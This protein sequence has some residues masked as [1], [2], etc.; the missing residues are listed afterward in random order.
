MLR[1]FSKFQ[2]SSKVILLIFS[3]VLLVSMLVFFIP[4]TNLPGM[5]GGGNTDD[6]SA[7]IAKV[8]SYDI[9]LKRISQ[10]VAERRAGL[11]PGTRY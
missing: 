3:L 2:R 5:N 6:G 4:T 1:F 9:T 11:C 10:P 7:V 8:G